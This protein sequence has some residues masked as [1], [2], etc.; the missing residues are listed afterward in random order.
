M[1]NLADRYIAAKAALDVAQAAVDA[2]N[3]EI[4]ALGVDRLEGTE[5]DV[6]NVLS[7]RTSIDVKLAKQALTVEQIAAA[8][9]TLDTKKVEGF[10]EADAIASALIITKT[11]TESLRIV[12]KKEAKAA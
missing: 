3:A 12:E 2:I 4:K 10:L 8:A 11:V 7:E 1:N 9:K 5:K 6:I